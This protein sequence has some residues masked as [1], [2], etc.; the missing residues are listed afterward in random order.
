MTTATEY[1]VLSL[2]VYSSTIENKT[3]LPSGWELAESL[4]P[5]TDDAF[6][7]SYGIFRRKGSTEIVLAYAGTNQ[8]VDWLANGTSAIGLSSTQ[9]TSAAIAYL[10][11]K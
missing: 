8:G 1:A 11:A 10:K 2:Y 9:A 4:H 5:D 7:F 6:G 3:E